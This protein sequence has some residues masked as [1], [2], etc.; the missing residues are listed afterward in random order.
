[1]QQKQKK[2]R[3]VGKFDVVLCGLTY[4]KSLSAVGLRSTSSSGFS[5][6]EDERDTP[7]NQMLDL[8]T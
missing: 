1:M 8:K 3:S 7:E 5:V 4:F 6:E 2:A